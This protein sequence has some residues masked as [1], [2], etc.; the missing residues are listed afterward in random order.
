MRAVNSSRKP[1]ITACTMMSVATPSITP[2]SAY[3]AMT[4][5]PPSRRRARRYRQAIVHSKAEKGAGLDGK[6]KRPRGVTRARTVVAGA[7]GV[8]PQSRGLAGARAPANL[9]QVDAR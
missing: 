4:E 7:P 9:D 2:I 3:Q 8:K 6:G 5:I 1:I